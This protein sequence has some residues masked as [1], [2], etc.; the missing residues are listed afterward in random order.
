M[1]NLKLNRAQMSHRDVLQWIATKKEIL[2]NEI[3]ALFGD[4]AYVKLYA[5]DLEEPGESKIKED[6]IFYQNKSY[7]VVKASAAKNSA[8][9][10]I[11]E[12]DY[13][14]RFDTLLIKYNTL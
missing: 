13:N 8:V 11:R 1:E 9:L 7:F 12:N 2:E 14:P 5:L 4:Q 6:Q 10:G 3:K